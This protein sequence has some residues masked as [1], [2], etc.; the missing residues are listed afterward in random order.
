MRA[1]PPCVTNG[2]SNPDPRLVEPQPLTRRD[3]QLCV[4]EIDPRHPLGDRMLDLEARVHLQEVE[5]AVVGDEE[6]HGAGVGIADAARRGDRGGGEAVAQRRVHHR[7]WRFLDDLLVPPLNRALALAE[8]HGGA[9]LIGEDLDLDVMRPIEVALEEDA[10]V[11]TPTGSRRGEFGGGIGT[12][13][14]PY[15]RAGGG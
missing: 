5:A 9:V 3:P 2:R 15:R 12:M 11:S 10:A 8:V 6:L 14:I 13:R 4:H 1:G 7:R